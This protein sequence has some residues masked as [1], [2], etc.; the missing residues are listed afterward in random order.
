[1]FSD[2]AVRYAD[3]NETMSTTLD[4]SEPS[5]PQSFLVEPDTPGPMNRACLLD[6]SKFLVDGSDDDCNDL[7]S[8]TVPETPR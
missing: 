2:Y 8:V 7:S 4:M 6:D 3:R 1:M 5:S